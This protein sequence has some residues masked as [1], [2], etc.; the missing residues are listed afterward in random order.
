MKAPTFR[1]S[2]AAFR[3]ISTL[4]ADFYL[5]NIGL[6][7]AVGVSSLGAIWGAEAFVTRWGSCALSAVRIMASGLHVGTSYGQGDA[8]VNG[9]GCM[10]APLMTRRCHGHWGS[11]PWWVEACGLALHP[12]AQ[13]IV[14]IWVSSLFIHEFTW[15]VEFTLMLPACRVHMGIRSA[16]TC[17][18][19]CSL[20]DF[21]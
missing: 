16:A 8:I 1:I 21:L 14:N 2:R 13:N 9:R 3:Y 19:A 7:V 17:V 15:H 5:Q 6:F 12:I 20:V 10:W 18:C 11:L 4:A